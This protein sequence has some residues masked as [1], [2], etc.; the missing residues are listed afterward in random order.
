MPTTAPK[1]F[2]PHR[3]TPDR[4]A[5][6]VVY[7]SLVRDWIRLCALPSIPATLGKWAREQPALAGCESLPALLDRIDDGTARETDELL[8]ALITLAQA[9]QQLGG[10]VVLQAMLP[11]LKLIAYS[12]SGTN[13]DDYELQD[14]RQIGIVEFWDVLNT[15][16]VER[17]RRKVAANLALDT[18]HRLTATKRHA[19][20]EY[21][22]DPHATDLEDYEIH[23]RVDQVAYD[24]PTS[25]DAD[26]RTTEAIEPTANILEVMAWALE[27]SAITPDEASLLVRV[28]APAHDEEGGAT[29]VAEQLGLSPTA[30]RQRCSRARRALIA[31]VRSH[32]DGLPLI[33][34]PAN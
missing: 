20:G 17:R 4:Y 25:L 23:S 22:V 15:Y 26:T 8:I 31:A 34:Q 27:I 5:M 24:D 6:G 14:R 1:V 18:L 16:P 11:K 9:G 29:A 21:T 28:Y 2:R 7:E 10:Q 30:V 13:S 33:P 12:T 3:Y 19:V 32:A